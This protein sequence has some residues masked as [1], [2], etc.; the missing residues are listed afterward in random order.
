MEFRLPTV[1]VVLT[2]CTHMPVCGYACEPLRAVVL[3]TEAKSRWTR[4]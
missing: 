1:G 3:R 2:V 4:S